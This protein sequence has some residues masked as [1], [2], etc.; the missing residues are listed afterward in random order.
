MVL[1][2]T[3]RRQKNP[4]ISGDQRNGIKFNNRQYIVI[5]IIYCMNLVR[6]YI[7]WN[8]NDI[9]YLYIPHNSFTLFY[10][11]NVTEFPKWITISLL[12]NLQTSHV[13]ERR[14]SHKGTTTYRRGMF[15]WEIILYLMLL[16]NVS[17]LSLRK[18]LHVLSCASITICGV[19]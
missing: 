16:D 12:N 11:K 7:S 5:V 3:M 4:E 18:C 15:T 19:D 9:F 1:S 10:F 13:Y 2:W 14:T 8:M 17:V 6:I